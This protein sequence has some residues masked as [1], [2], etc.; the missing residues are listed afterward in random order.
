M[1]VVKTKPLFRLPLFFTLDDEK[2]AAIIPG[3]T[4]AGLKVLRQKFEEEAGVGVLTVD[5]PVYAERWKQADLTLE[6]RMRVGYGWA[7]WGAFE[8]QAA[9]QANAAADS[10]SAPLN[11]SDF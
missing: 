9:L 7:A 6:Q 1:E 5:D 11:D 10:A 2:I 4:V 3:V 8:H